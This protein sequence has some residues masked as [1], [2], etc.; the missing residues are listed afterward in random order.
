[1]KCSECSNKVQKFGKV[2]NEQ[3]YF[4]VKCNKTFSKKSIKREVERKE[5]Y[6]R[7]KKMYIEDNLSTIEI[8]KILGVSSTVPQ[9]IIK[10][11][12]ISKTISEAKKGKVRISKLP[13]QKI[14]NFYLDGD[15]SIEISE[16]LN[17]SKRSV[18]NILE[19]HG[20]ERNNIYEYKHDKID[21]IKKLYLNGNSMNKVSEK[22]NIPYTT[23]N[24]NLHKLGIVRTEDKFR[25]GINYEE[26]LEVLPAFKKYRSDVMKITNKQKIYKLVN[27]DRRGLCGVDGVY[28]LD[29]K[30]SILE[31]F[32][33][34]IEPEI[35]GDIKNLEF[36]PWEENLNKGSKCSI[37]EKELRKGV[38]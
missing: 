16:K 30:F 31:G 32:K 23:I 12:G 7:I 1:M 10:K 21:E 37:T 36:I 22:L 25:I 26:Y 15:S 14:I 17:I 13:A 2:N 33:Q 20:I 29:H 27:F 5:K 18:L 19:K 4:C 34:G 8:A 9:R 24:T 11:M 6:E 38:K 35:I 3:R 28:Q